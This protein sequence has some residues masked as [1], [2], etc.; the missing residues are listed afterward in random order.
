MEKPYDIKALAEKLK[1]KGL[2]VADEVLKDVVGET[3]DWVTESAKLSPTPFDDVAAL[4]APKVKE[5]AFSAIDKV[6][7]H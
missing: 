7:G 2:D 1:A 4:V 3:L 6:T 5:V